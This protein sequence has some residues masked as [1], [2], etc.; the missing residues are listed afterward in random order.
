MILMPLTHCYCNVC[1]CQHFLACF[2]WFTIE[3]FC[4]YSSKE[5]DALPLFFN[6]ASGAMTYIIPQE[7]KQFM[8]EQA[9]AETRNLKFEYFSRND[10][11][12]GIY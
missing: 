4:S 2:T 1:T 12:T 3:I 9:G 7:L 5:E 11:S 10:D 6:R 8:A